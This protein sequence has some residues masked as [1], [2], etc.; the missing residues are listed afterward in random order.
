MAS[1]RDYEAALRERLHDKEGSYEGFDRLAKL[2]L[3]LVA[4]ERDKMIVAIARVIR[5]AD[6]AGVSADAIHLAYNLSIY[7]PE[8]DDAV[9]ARAV[10]TRASASIR[11]QAANY[12]SYRHQAAGMAMMA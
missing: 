4:P 9:D 11:R 10:D 5:S 1:V 7:T 12:R 6:N 2:Y 8:V 3:A